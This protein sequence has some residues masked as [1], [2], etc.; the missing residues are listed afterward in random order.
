MQDVWTETFVATVTESDFAGRIRPSAIL[1][2]MQN[3]ADRHL[4][5]AGVPV[6]RLLEQGL[7]WVLMTTRIQLETT[8]KLGDPLKLETWSIGAAGVLWT[9]DYR[10]LGTDGVE[11]MRAST[12]WTL[13]DIVKR[14]ILRP[15]A[16]P[17]P[18]PVSSRSSLS[19]PPEKVSTP[20]HGIEWSE[21]VAYAVPY[22][23]VD[24]YGHMN[25]ARYADLCTDLMAPEQLRD[26]DLASLRITY[27]QEAAMGD[28][29]QLRCGQ[30]GDEWFVFGESEKGRKMFE[31]VSKLKPKTKLF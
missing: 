19:G 28:R 18:L 26:F 2:A 3:A 8:P 17:F 15:S 30:R 9:R 22:S 25:N 7:A 20:D 31:A 6:A 16:F 24:C 10:L 13:V 12:A 27:S 1:A 4:E 14:R 5:D 29:I 21:P 23:A 11:V